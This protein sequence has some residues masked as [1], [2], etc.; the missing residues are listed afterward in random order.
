[1][2]CAAVWLAKWKAVFWVTAAVFEKDWRT[3]FWS[4]P[5]KC[6]DRCFGIEIKSMRRSSR[7]QLKEILGAR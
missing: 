7:I 2:K 4:Y 3:P 6:V 5:L 1:M